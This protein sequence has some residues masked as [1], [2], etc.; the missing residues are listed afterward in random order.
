MPM[1]NPASAGRKQGSS[2]VVRLAAVDDMEDSSHTAP[3]QLPLA[4]H[5]LTRRYGLTP[6]TASAVVEAN[7]W[8][9]R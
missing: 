9:C 5:R 3:S 7:G 8:G 6:S 1:K 2:I 4:A